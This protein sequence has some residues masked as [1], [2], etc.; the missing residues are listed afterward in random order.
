[1]PHFPQGPGSVENSNQT[2]APQ[3]IAKDPSE[4]EEKFLV[5]KPEPVFSELIATD[6]GNRR[7]DFKG[8]KYEVIKTVEGKMVEVIP[9]SLDENGSAV[10]EDVINASELSN[11]LRIALLSPKEVAEK[12]DTARS[13]LTQLTFT[14]PNSYKLVAAE[15]KKLLENDITE[16]TQRTLAQ[17]IFLKFGTR[18][19]YRAFF[20]GDGISSGLNGTAFHDEIKKLESARLV[21]AG[22]SAL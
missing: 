16:D 9:Y 13:F 15:A 11:E 6:A 22:Y 19:I 4:L 1:M 7:V 14:D 8:K 17:D 21:K 18:E 10:Y 20:G 12:N 2:A 5:K 3:P